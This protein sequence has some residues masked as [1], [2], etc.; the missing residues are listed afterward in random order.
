MRTRYALLAVLVAALCVAVPST[1]LAKAKVSFSD[2]R[3]VYHVASG[4]NLTVTGRIHT[5]AKIKPDWSM[6]APVVIQ[7]SYHGAWKDVVVVRIASRGGFS[8]TLRKPHSGEYRILYP[9]CN[10]CQPKH[11]HFD[12]RHGTRSTGLGYPIKLAPYLS[13]RNVSSMFFG[14]TPKSQ[15]TRSLAMIAAQPVTFSVNTSQSPEAMTGYRLTF[16]VSASVTGVTYTPV[17]TSPSKLGFMGK[18]LVSLVATVPV[19]DPVSDD[20]YNYYK[21]RATWVGN[22]FTYPGSAEATT[23]GIR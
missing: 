6:H 21:V 10:H 2:V 7:R 20:W 22:G 12:V 13:I 23:G 9:G 15:R 3:G 1:A 11:F 8:A 4:H 18:Q 5:S 14:S 17:Y 19:F 16:N